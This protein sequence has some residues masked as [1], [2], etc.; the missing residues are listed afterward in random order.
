[1]DKD[2][3]ILDFV[4]YRQFRLD[5]EEEKANEDLREDVMNWMFAPGEYTTDSFTFTWENDD[6]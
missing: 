1:V 2:N 5:M 3:N 4:A 6:E